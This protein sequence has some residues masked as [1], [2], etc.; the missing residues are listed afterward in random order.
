M[1]YKYSNV[2]SPSCHA[3]HC[4]V[5][6]L[7]GTLVTQSSGKAASHQ[8]RISRNTL[9]ATNNKD[10]TIDGFLVHKGNLMVRAVF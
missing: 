6:L 5:F 2:S 3:I 4:C 8:H 10:E 1:Q 7:S 9:N